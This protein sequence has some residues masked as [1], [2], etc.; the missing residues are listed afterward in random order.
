MLE[1]VVVDA[2]VVVTKLAADNDETSVVGGGEL[3]LLACISSCSSFPFDS[4][5][6]S[7]LEVS[8]TITVVDVCKLSGG[9]ESISE[10]IFATP[11]GPR[12]N[13]QRAGY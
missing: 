1:T 6:F 11:D 12:S 13:T 4:S 5:G 2:A 3:L 9:P 10:L 8:K 7:V